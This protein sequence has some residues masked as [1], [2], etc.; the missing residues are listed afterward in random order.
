MITFLRFSLL[1]LTLTMPLLRAEPPT[2]VT[3]GSGIYLTTT[4]GNTYITL[5]PLE[6]NAGTTSTNT[7]TTMTTFQ[8]LD[9]YGNS[10]GS[11]FVYGNT[12][13][14]Q[15]ASNSFWVTLDPAPGYIRN[16]APMLLPWEELQLI[17][18]N[19][20]SGDTAQY[21]DQVYL[22]RYSDVTGT[23][24]TIINN[25]GSVTTTTDMGQATPL[26]IQ[27][28]VGF[29][30]YSQADNGNDQVHYTGVFLLTTTDG[31][32]WLNMTP[33][34]PNAGYLSTDIYTN[35]YYIYSMND[36]LNSDVA[37]PTY[38][39]PISIA[40]S[41][42]YV[43]LNLSPGYVRNNV[44]T[45]SPAGVWE[46]LYFISV[47]GHNGDLMCFNDQVYL[48]RNGLIQ[49]NFVTEYLMIDGQGNVSTTFNLLE[50]T[51]LMLS[52]GF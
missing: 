26:V 4:D 18:I 37:Q 20:R 22:G 51:P 28:V 5:N 47:N 43:T 21:G 19:A 12:V 36:A 33:N 7:D 32:S 49:G 14:M 48:A 23:V 41:S 39:A 52:D 30:P 44:S 46:Q 38:G 25:D 45:G 1:L 16:N 2:T 13:S 10:S 6:A 11:N 35:I 8:L 27:E 50:A 29:V 3:F 15:L 17:P 31:V 34:S 9:G 40:A 42:N 24:Y